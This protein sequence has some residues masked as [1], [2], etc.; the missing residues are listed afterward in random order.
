MLKLS[1]A[2][3]FATLDLPA[4]ENAEL[5]D[6]E[7]N[8]TLLAHEF[9]SAKEMVVAGVNKW[10]AEDLE[11]LMTSTLTLEAPFEMKCGG[12]PVHGYLDLKA[13]YKIGA[14]NG[15]TVVADWKTTSGALDKT[16]QD[17]LVDSWQFRTYAVAADADY[18][19]YRGIS[20]KGTTREVFIEVPKGPR[21][22]HAVNSYYCSVGD[23]IRSISKNDVWPQHKPSACGMFGTT[24]PFKSDCD[25]DIAPRYSIPIEEISLSYSGAERFLSCPEKYRRINKADKGVDGSDSTRLGSSVHRG[26]EEVWKQAFKRYGEN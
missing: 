7:G 2:D 18:I 9:T 21:L 4:I 15:K 22:L 3:I 8:T 12:Y 23:M 19:S 1:S 17:K 11:L 20:N 25:L 24:C 16:W 14:L 26:L 6:A 5:T 10:L 13:T